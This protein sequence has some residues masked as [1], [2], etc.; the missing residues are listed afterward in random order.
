MAIDSLEGGGAM[1]I[2]GS[3]FEEAWKDVPMREKGLKL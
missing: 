1:W 2:R 3:G